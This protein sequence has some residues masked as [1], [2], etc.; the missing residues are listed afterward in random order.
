MKKTIFAL[1]AVLLLVLIAAC[2]DFSPKASTD[3]DDGLPLYTEDGR[4]MVHFDILQPVNQNRALTDALAKGGVDYYEVAF[5]DPLYDTPVGTH[6]KI[7]RAAWDYSKPGRI[8]VPEGDYFGAGKAVLFAG[9]YSDRTLLAVGILTKIDGTA[10][11]AAAAQIEPNTNNVTFTL[12]PLINDIKP[13]PASSFKITAPSSPNYSTSAISAIN[14]PKAEIDGI[15]YPL[16]RIPRDSE[17]TTATYD[18]TIPSITITVSGSPTPY[19]TN[20]GI[21]IKGPGK[22]ISSGFFYQDDKGVTVKGVDPDPIL[23]DGNA[24]TGTF[25]LKIDTTGLDAALSRLSIEVPVNA[26]DIALDAPA[27]WYI[28]GGMSQNVLDAGAGINSLGGAILLAVGPVKINGII[29]NPEFPD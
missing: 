7:Y 10:L 14:F 8:A 18:V 3:P 26:I 1:I 12:A 9:R 21:I 16:F 29:I 23:P 27:T 20:A 13:D 11:T 25:T 24:I 5:K 17:D 22:L 2:E 6:L 4:R 15:F 28:R 19:P